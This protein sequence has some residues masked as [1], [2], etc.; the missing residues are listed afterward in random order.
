MK[1]N[2]LV[3]IEDGEKQEYRVL[4][5]V[6]DLEGKSYV[7]YTKDEVNDKGEVIS[8]AAE[9]IENKETGNVK[10]ISIKDDKVW[11]YIKEIMNSVQ[12][13]EKEGK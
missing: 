7:L 9:Y 13:K 4:L 2:K 5:N 1:D 10:L 3:L 6:E 8:Y 12:D 11:E